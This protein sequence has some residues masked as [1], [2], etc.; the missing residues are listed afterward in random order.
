M[1]GWNDGSGQ[2]L[3]SL[4]ELVERF[5]VDRIHKGGAK[6]DYEKARWFN[7]EW[8][9]KTDDELL[10]EKLM[11]LWQ[12]KNITLDPAYINKVVKMVKDRC[13]LLNDF[14]EQSSFFFQ[15]PASYDVASVKPKWND[16]KKTFFEDFITELDG[17]NDFDAAAIE[18]CFKDLATAKN[19][20][21]GELQLPFRIMLVGGKFGPPVFEIA[22]TIGLEQTK[23]RIR[24][25]LAAF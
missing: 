8:I 20:K 14:W 10:S 21:A 17:V 13:F 16:D 25:A 3:F 19:I 1:L 22:S 9:K 4:D 23:E 15:L 18:A 24:R 7:H 2:E 11:L 6:F 12:D 5:S